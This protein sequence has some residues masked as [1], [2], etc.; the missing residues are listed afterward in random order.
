MESKA[1]NTILFQQESEQWKADVVFCRDE[2]KVL[3][4]YLQEVIEKNTASARKNEIAQFQHKLSEKIEMSYELMGAIRVHDEILRMATPDNE[5]IEI[6][7]AQAM[8][9]EKVTEFRKAYSALKSLFV[10]FLA[11]ADFIV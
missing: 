2:I 11:K 5:Y 6:E 1:F 4:R 3:N 7:D 10:R 9:K 8:L